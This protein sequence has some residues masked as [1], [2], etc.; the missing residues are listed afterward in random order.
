[1]RTRLR[2]LAR[3]TARA[4][5][6]CTILAAGILSGVTFAHDGAVT[7]AS[8]GALWVTPGIGGHV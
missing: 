3:P 8:G 1:M 2:P 5:R 4:A 6:G 7:R